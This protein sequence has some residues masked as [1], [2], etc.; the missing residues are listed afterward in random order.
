MEV[1][2]VGGGV[3]GMITALLLSQKGI[4]ATIYEASSQLGGR[5]AYQEGKGYRIDQGPTIVLLPDM[6]IDILEEAGIPRSE[7]SL[8]ECEPMY[9]INYTDGQHFYKWRDKQ[10]QVEEI[11]RV[12]PQEGKHF[13]SYMKDMESMF[14]RGKEAF[15]DR[16][17]L[18]KKEFYTWKNLSLLTKMKAY[19][20]VREITRKYFKDE[21]LID[22]FSLQTL[23]I[24][25]APF[26]SPGLYTL[27]PYAEHAYGVWY[28]KGG[29]AGLSMR[30]QEELLKRGVK[31]HLNTRIDGFEL[32]GAQ[33]AGVK[34]GDQIFRHDAV[35]YNGDFPHLGG[36][37]EQ[38]TT[39]VPSRDDLRSMN[40]SHESP[41]SR[42]MKRK[43]FKKNY[44]S[45]SGCV[46]IYLGVK[47]RW[48]DADVHQFFLPESLQAGLQHIFLEQRLPEH[49]SFYVFNPVKLD[50]DAAPE[51]E[52]VL[53]ILVPVPTKGKVDFQQETSALVDRVID[54]A[55]ERGF[56][57][58]RE[59]ISWMDIRTPADAEKEG[60]YLGGSF[61]IAPILS[62]SGPFRPQIVPYPIKN[63]YAVGASI[64]PGGGIPIVMQGARL[65]AQQMVKEMIV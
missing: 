10:K 43:S 7:L 8:L 30:L 22:A 56:A 15:L 19:K 1:G 25:G 64:H 29:Y 3:G 24:G 49:P 23:Y 61:G 42:L 21:R 57:G 62:Q 55:E 59:A 20:S 9:R 44:T 65:L 36:L 4:K 53:Y 37:L 26:Q 35:V 39:D 38:S 51:G 18:R 32:T 41:S 6:I 46:L 14:S 27:L 47:K 40:K 31:L 52:S 11:E 16:P 2:I 48:V 28:L 12:F 13:L 5:L 50:P 33:C 63:L 17:F 58:L 34:V 45:S 54:E 60:L